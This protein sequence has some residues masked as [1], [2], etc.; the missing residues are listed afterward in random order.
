MQMVFKIAERK[1]SKKTKYVAALTTVEVRLKG[2]KD[3]VDEIYNDI[4]ENILN[5]GR[6]VY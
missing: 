3:I 6:I 5:E 1:K 4:V 2:N